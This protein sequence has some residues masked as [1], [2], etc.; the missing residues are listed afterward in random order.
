MQAC[1]VSPFRLIRPVAF[2]AV[3]ATAGHGPPD[4]CRTA[5]GESDVPRDHLQRVANRAESNVKPRVFYG[6]FPN[7]TIY[8]RDVVPGGWRDVFLADTSQPGQ[9]TV[10][11]AKEGRLRVDR[12]EA[13]GRAGADRAGRGTRRRSTK[14]DE[15]EGGDYDSTIIHLDPTTVFPS[16]APTKTEREMSIAELKASIVAGARAE[17]SGP[18]PAVH[19]SAEIFDSGRVP[20]AGAHWP[21]AWHQ[22]S[23]GRAVC[24]LR[25]RLRRDFRLLRRAVD[26]ARRRSHRTDSGRAWPRGFRMLIFGVAG[27]AL[28][29][30]R[31][32]SPDQPI[33]ISLPA[34]WRARRGG[35]GRCVGAWAGGS[36]RHE[37]CSSFGSRT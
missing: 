37:S 13:I 11:F 10:Y 36:R 9:T 30:W 6:E 5:R 17:R 19:D 29:F 14:P 15:Y 20:G 21:G 23:E 35:Q 27:V 4:H 24:E 26:G 1:G 25:A 32:G 12:D 16:I 28:L 18:Q 3:L 7:R 33:R 31:A 8:A 2:V 22:P 34:F